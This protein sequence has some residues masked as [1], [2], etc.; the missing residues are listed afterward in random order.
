MRLHD[1][2]DRVHEKEKHFI[3]AL[4]PQQQ[5]SNPF[6][7]TDHPQEKQLCIS[8]R[9]LQLKDFLLL[10]TLGTGEQSQLM[11]HGVTV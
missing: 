1:I 7:V 4:R 11:G 5:T 3:Q 10:K 6:L 9:T 8:S 2:Q